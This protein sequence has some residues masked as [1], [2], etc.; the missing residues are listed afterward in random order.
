MLAI[1][2]A[3][4]REPAAEPT[5]LP[6]GPPFHVRVPLLD[7]APNHYAIGSKRAWKKRRY[8]GS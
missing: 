4:C 5:F 6:G 1:L 7:G 8:F 2:P 3:G